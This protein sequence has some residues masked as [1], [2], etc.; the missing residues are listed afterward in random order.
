M[1]GKMLGKKHGKNGKEKTEKKTRKNNEKKR[2]N[3]RKKNAKI[4]WR[5]LL[6]GGFINNFRKV[7]HFVYERCINGTPTLYIYIFIYLF[8]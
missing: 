4:G 1:E 6:R 5:T 7:A 3:D 2:K 8:S